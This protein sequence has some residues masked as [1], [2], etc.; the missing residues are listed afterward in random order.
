M[1]LAKLRKHSHKEQILLI[2]TEMLQTEMYG[3]LI[4]GIAKDAA[5][6]NWMYLQS[7]GQAEAG[8]EDDK[9]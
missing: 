5:S 8:V 4:T 2:R 3:E 1:E 6:C 9:H 7:H